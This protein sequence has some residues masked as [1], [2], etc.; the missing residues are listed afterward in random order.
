MDESLLDD[1]VRLAEEFKIP[2]KRLGVLH[3]FPLEDSVIYGF[4]KETMGSMCVGYVYKIVSTSQTQ[5]GQQIRL[6]EYMTN[7]KIRFLAITCEDPTFEA[8]YNFLWQHTNYIL[9]DNLQSD[10][11]MEQDTTY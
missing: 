7:D 6:T 11:S 2:E 5:N 8:V 4:V 10:L 1:Y 9:L 3:S